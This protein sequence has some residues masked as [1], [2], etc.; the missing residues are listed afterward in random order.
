MSEQVLWFPLN[1]FCMIYEHFLPVLGEIYFV[2]ST[3]LYQSSVVSFG[4]FSMFLAILPVMY[5]DDLYCFHIEY[6]F[7]VYAQVQ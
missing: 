3:L 7:R 5:E 2:L 4:A 6:L 1:T